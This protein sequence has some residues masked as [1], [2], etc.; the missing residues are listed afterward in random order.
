MHEAWTA[1][2][3]GSLPIGAAVTD[4]QGCILARG[5]NCIHDE[6]EDGQPLSGHRLAHAE[7]NALLQVDW[8]RIDARACVL[9]T[10]TEPCPLCVGAIRMTLI[11]EVRY[12]AQDE[13]AGSIQL[14]EST[15]FLRKG[16]IKVV[17][18][19]QADLEVILIALLVEFALNYANESI[20]PAKYRQLASID[21]AGA[22]L[23]KELFASKQ[24]R[25]WR[26]EGKAASFVLNQLAEY[27]E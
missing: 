25:H 23:G 2:C 4:N 15:P 12:A 1:Y 9:Y 3:K 26:E 19:Q 5:R 17:H 8:R 7:M 13:V 22:H 6:M 18:P 11:G 24:L 20:E 27:T 14:L 21:S 10:T 16:Q